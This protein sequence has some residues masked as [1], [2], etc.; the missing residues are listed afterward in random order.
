MLGEAQIWFRRERPRT[1][2]VL[3]IYRLVETHM[4]CNL[5]TLITFLDYEEACDKVVTNKLW[6]VMIDEG[7]PQH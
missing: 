6:Q 2:Y 1:G 5:E 4:E 7:F 3:I